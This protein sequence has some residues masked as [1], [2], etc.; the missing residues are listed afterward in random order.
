MATVRATETVA[1]SHPEHGGLIV[2]H[3]GEDYPS[4]HILVETYGWVFEQDNVEQATAA[5]GERRKVTRKKTA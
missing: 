1:L 2:V 3:R 5:P 4:D